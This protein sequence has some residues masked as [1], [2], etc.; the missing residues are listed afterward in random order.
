MLKLRTVDFL[1][2]QVYFKN[3]FWSHG[4]DLQ[5]LCAFKLAL[6]K[7]SKSLLY[8]QGKVQAYIVMLCTSRFQIYLVSLQHFLYFCYVSLLSTFLLWRIKRDNFPSVLVMYPDDLQNLWSFVDKWSSI[9]FVLSVYQVSILSIS[10][11]KP[12]ITLVLFVSCLNINKIL[13]L[14]WIMT[15]FVF[16]VVCYLLGFLLMWYTD[17]VT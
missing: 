15:S 12:G 5:F 3:K 14:T 10:A 17:M 9:M 6:W 2:N 4:G 7:C 8:V 13:P 1:S 16:T 11:L